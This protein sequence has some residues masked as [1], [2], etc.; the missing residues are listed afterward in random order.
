MV[1]NV[2]EAAVEIC[3]VRWGEVSPPL[4]I[5]GRTKTPTSVVKRHDIIHYY[6]IVWQRR[7]PR[8]GGA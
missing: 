1:T 6:L 4:H 3:L 7:V 2:C 5:K 8:G